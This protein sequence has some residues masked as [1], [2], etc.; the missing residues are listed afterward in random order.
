MT[1]YLEALGD[2]DK[3][4]INDLTMKTVMLMALTRPSRSADL[5]SLNLEQRRYSPEGVTF[6]PTK[7]AKQSRQSKTLAEFFFPAFPSNARLCPVTMLRMY[8]KRTRDR[9]GNQSPCH[10]FISLI[11]PYN[12]VTSSTIARWIKSILAK[13]GIDTNIF[14]AH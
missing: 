5:A 4:Q 11:R 10:L 6:A 8:E 13:L 1:T 9:R 12:P 3:L 7:L 14:K 2:N